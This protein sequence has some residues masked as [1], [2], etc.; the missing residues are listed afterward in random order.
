MSRKRILFIL[1]LALLSCIESAWADRL[2]NRPV[3]RTES[4]QLDKDTMQKLQAEPVPENFRSNPA[5]YQIAKLF[6][7]DAEYFPVP[8]AINDPDATI[9]YIDSWQAERTYGGQRGHDGCDLMA[10]IQKRNYYPIV[11]VS[12]GIIEKI[13]WLELGGYRIG[14][15]SKSGVYYYYAHLSEYAPGIHEGQKVSAGELIAYMG[16]TGYGKEEG[17]CGNFPVHLHFGMYLDNADGE[18]IC[19]NTYPLLQALEEKKLRYLY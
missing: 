6:Y 2:Q 8:D 11:S 9:S 19:Y 14:I 7:Q 4:G 1:L 3:T 13:G 12:D 16:D 18:E 17:T 5:A 15:R 10:S